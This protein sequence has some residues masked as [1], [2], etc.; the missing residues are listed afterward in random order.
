MNHIILYRLFVFTVTLQNVAQCDGPTVS[1]A[2]GIS[3]F[4]IFIVVGVLQLDKNDKISDFV[5]IN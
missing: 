1:A 2:A 5:N 3:C 4:I